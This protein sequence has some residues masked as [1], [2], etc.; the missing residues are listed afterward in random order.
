MFSNIFHKKGIIK[1][2]F[3]VS[4]LFFLSYNLQAQQDL[5]LLE[6][7]FTKNLVNTT[8]IQ[9]RCHKVNIRNDSLTE[10]KEDS[11]SPLHLEKFIMGNKLAI[12]MLDGYYI[13]LGTYNVIAEKVESFD[14]NE[15]VPVNKVKIF[16][17]KSKQLLFNE[18]SVLIQNTA[19]KDYFLLTESILD[20]IDPRNQTPLS[21]AAELKV[22]QNTPELPKIENEKTEQKSNIAFTKNH[23]YTKKEFDALLKESSSLSKRLEKY[24]KKMAQGVTTGISK[25][26]Q[27]DIANA[28]RLRKKLS[29]FVTIIT[30]NK[31]EEEYFE[32]DKDRAKYRNLINSLNPTSRY[33][34]F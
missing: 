22:N 23:I 15:L 16:N 25:D 12:T 2:F 11:I 5:Y 7:E 19:T 33:A 28:R 27:K 1:L 14:T 9:G 6:S 24:R 30:D 20:K 21:D 34:K 32:S 10:N 3:W 13:N 31:W 26:W 4:A 17:I 29:D 18:N 8:S